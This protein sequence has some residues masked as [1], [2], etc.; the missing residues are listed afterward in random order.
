MKI[1][2]YDKKGKEVKKVELPR[3]FHTP[4]RKDLIKRTVLSHQ[5]ARV[6]PH[7]SSYMAGRRSSAKFEATRSGYGHS[8]NLSAARVPRLMMRGGR[9]T[10]K[11]MNVPQAVGG[12]RSHPPKAEKIWKIKVNLKERKFAIRSALAATADKVLVAERGHKLSDLETPVVFVNE[13]EQLNKTADVKQ[14]LELIGLSDELIRSSKK[15]VRAGKGKMRGRKYKR[16]KGPLIV[17]S[18]YKVPLIKAA[19]NIPGIDVINVKDI[20]AESLAPGTHFGRLVIF[21][22]AALEK[23]EKDG[24]FI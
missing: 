15:K 2:V 9:R 12:P 20:N 6:Q 21:S 22:E 18:E 1:P 13:I 7:G 17:V 11:V 8:Y 19:R 24:L 10:G 3:Q 23:I 14:L 16:V 4:I 5:K